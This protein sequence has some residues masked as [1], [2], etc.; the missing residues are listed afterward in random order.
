[1]L[2]L[3]LISSGQHLKLINKGWAPDGDVD[4]IV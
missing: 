3:M 4:A 1:M 2:S